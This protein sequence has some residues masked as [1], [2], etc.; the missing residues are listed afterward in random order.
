[1]THLT[2][3][4]LA[5]AA[6]CLRVV[7]KVDTRRG[8]S[9]ELVPAGSIGYVLAHRKSDATYLVMW[10]RPR[11]YSTDNRCSAHLA[12]ECEPVGRGVE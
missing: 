8:I 6:K 7:A 11:E 4:E 10:D 1:M 5:K 9:E 2:K 3:P 12:S